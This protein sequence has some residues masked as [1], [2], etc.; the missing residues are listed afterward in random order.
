V[1]DAPEVDNNEGQVETQ[2]AE[3]EGADDQAQAEEKSR[4]A[5]RRERDKALKERLKHEAAEATARAEQAERELA[6]YKQRIEAQPPKAD[7]FPDYETYVAARAAWEV[8]KTTAQDRSEDLERDVRS[9]RE[10]VEAISAQ[11]QM[12]LDQRYVESMT[13]AKAA[14]PDF[15]QV[16]GNP[17]LFPKGTALPDLIKLSD[18]P[19]RLAYHV[20][21]NRALHD[22]LLRLHPIEAA[23]VLGRLEAGLTRPTPRTQTNAPPPI[24]PVKATGGAG[25]DPRKMS[26][27]E[28]KAFREKGGTL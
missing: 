11:E 10:R 26:Y 1:G 14:F 2:T 22:E 19:A 27:S 25:K 23:R 28:F 9:S 3:A 21:S 15:D 13:E 6:K 18:D 5:Q 8:L 7:D 20:A 16:V 4:A 12:L 17:A 24:S